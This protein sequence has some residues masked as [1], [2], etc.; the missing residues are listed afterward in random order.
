MRRK[1]R[2]SA[3][4]DK[5]SRIWLLL[6]YCLH[7]GVCETTMLQPNNGLSTT[8]TARICSRNP[9]DVI[10][11]SPFSGNWLRVCTREPHE[12]SMTAYTRGSI[13]LSNPGGV[14]RISVRGLMSPFRLR[15]RKFGKFDY[16]M[17]HSEVYL[18]KYVVSIAPFSTRAC[19][20]CSQNIQQNALF[21]MFSHFNFSSNFPERSADPICPYVQTPMIKPVRCPDSEP[22]TSGVGPD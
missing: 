20:D 19:P 4:V 16:E 11:S 2:R 8:R 1:E 22:Q 14:R 15:R 18:N 3:P 5:L 17:V 6:G 10:L 7:S 12:N 13:R 21:C 9:I